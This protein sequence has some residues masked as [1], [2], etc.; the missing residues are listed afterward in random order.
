MPSN[1]GRQDSYRRDP[2]IHE[3]PSGFSWH[4]ELPERTSSPMG[5][6]KPLAR[7]V[8][9]EGEGIS[10]P[11]VVARRLEKL[12]ETGYGS[13]AELLY[14]VGE[15]SDACC[16]EKLVDL[17]SR[18]DY[19]TAEMT[20][21]LMREGYS[22]SR[23]ESRVA[24]ACELK[25]MSDERFAEYFIRAKVGAGWGPVRIERELSRRGIEASEVVGWPDAFFE[26][27]DVEGRARELLARKSV[28]E[29]NAYA[30]FVRFLVSRGYPTGV[31]K[32]AALARIHGVDELD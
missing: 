7:L 24:H 2:L 21:R 30:K 32:D 3:G 26:R 14:H 4:V 17:V 29:K 8:V 16:W 1:R 20:T 31:A 27:D 22:R 19:S 28:P 5:S 15:V 6:R 10:V 23:S 25:I 9:S 13:R 18:R 12:E 11:V